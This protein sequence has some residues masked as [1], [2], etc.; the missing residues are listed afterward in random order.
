ME[1]LLHEKAGAA[2]DGAVP[3]SKTADHRPPRRRLLPGVLG[4]MGAAVQGDAKMDW[5]RR[6]W[7]SREQY[8]TARVAPMGISFSSQTIILRR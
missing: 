2:T 1:S 3:Y 5:D 6:I 7:P 8:R 4:L